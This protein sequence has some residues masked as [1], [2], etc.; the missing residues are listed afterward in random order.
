MRER[1][2][3][4]IGG[5]VVGQAMYRLVSK[6][7][8]VPAFVQPGNNVLVYDPHVATWKNTTKEQINEC[9][10]AF[11]CVPT[12]TKEDG[13]CDTSIVEETVDWLETDLI[14]IRSTVAPGT[15]EQ[16][17]RKFNKR[18]VFQ[19]EYLGETPAHT[20]SDM[21]QR[22]FIILG[23]VLEDCVEIADFYK[24]FYNSLVQFHFCD[25][26]TAELCKYMENAFYAMKIIF[27]NEW[28]D[29]A[30]AHNVPFDLLRELWL[31]D[32]R[33]SRDHTFV[34]PEARGFG[35]KCLPK[36]CS[37]IVHSCLEKGFDPLFMRACLEIN[38]LMQ[39][40]D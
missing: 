26:M 20:L 39:K 33:V 31:A 24:C 19:P 22:G 28:Y 4:I 27:V 16:L 13:A 25:W 7:N 6:S 14:V 11:V 37:A 30:K 36:D 2:I 38:D 29:V 17:A 1:K 10:I 23:G 34:Y 32:T 8:F 18:I 5:G 21:S 15:C 9:N 3:G 35:G 12:P 40:N